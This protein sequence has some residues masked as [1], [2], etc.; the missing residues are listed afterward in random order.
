MAL[1]PIALTFF[2]GRWQ[3]GN[4]PIIGA[5]DHTAWHGNLVFDGARYFDGVMPDL[6][7]HMA[8]IVRSAEAMGLTPP[9]DGPTL[10]GIVR[11]GVAK[12]DPGLALYIRPMM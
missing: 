2:D 5:A 7:L 9:V 4:V 6:D 3:D 8:R 12:M 11:D 1:G 10:E